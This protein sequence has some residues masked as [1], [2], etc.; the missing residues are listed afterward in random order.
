[1]IRVRCGDSKRRQGF[2]GV[3]HRLPIGLA[4]HD[5]RDRVVFV[6]RHP[7]CPARK[8]RPFIRRRWGKAIS[9]DGLGND[10]WNELVD[11]FLNLIL[12]QELLLLEPG[13][14]QKIARGI[15]L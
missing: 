7:I 9:L 3:L 6:S 13:E 15:L 4:S 1:M 10:R 14:L 11:D 2:G 5:Y 12:E 8:E